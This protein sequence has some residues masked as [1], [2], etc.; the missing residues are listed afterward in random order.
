MPMVAAEKMWERTKVRHFND[1]EYTIMKGA[2][3]VTRKVGTECNNKNNQ[4][5]NSH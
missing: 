1:T 3:Y 2:L 5:T 4:D